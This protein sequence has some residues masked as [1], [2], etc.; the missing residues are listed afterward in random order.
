MRFKVAFVILISLILK[1]TILYSAT[2]LSVSELQT[3]LDSLKTELMVPDLSEE[4]E[5]TLLEQT[6]EAYYYLG[7]YPLSLINLKHAFEKYESIGDMA[8]VGE[9]LERQGVLYTELNDYKTAIDN[10]LKALTILEDIEDDRLISRVKLN[11]ATVYSQLND[12]KQT[13]I[14]VNDAKLFYEKNRKEY[15][16]GYISSLIFLSGI[17]LDQSKPDSALNFLNEALDFLK[18]HGGNFNLQGIYTNIGNVYNEQKEYDQALDFYYKA[19][20]IY[21]ENEHAKG[22]GSILTNIAAILSDQGKYSE[23]LA[24]F[25]EA[26]GYLKEINA[27][28]ELNTLYM[29][30]SITY[31]ELKEFEKSLEYY[32]LSQ[33]LKDSIMS[34]EIQTKIAN[35]Q[36]QYEIK[37]YEQELVTQKQES[38]LRQYILLFAISGL[39]VL[40]IILFFRYRLVRKNKVLQEADYNQEKINLT[41][42]L[43]FKNKQMESFAIHIIQKN[44]FLEKLVSD[45]DRIDKKSL[46]IDNVNTLKN[47]I[48]QN[49]HIEK[50]KEEF[51]NYV[52]QIHQSFFFKLEQKFPQLTK[53]ERRLCSL[54]ILD[55][56][57]KEIADLISISPETVKKVRYRLRKKFELNREDNLV[58][59]LKHI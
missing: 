57:I 53:A 43:E 55:L 41:N 24:N 40:W 12:Y 6:G 58:Q 51:H 42:E 36:N 32:H 59:F 47:S 2:K 1:S 52:D 27:L 17:Y 5:A 45:I 23:A 28:R 14:Y 39:F 44:E 18:N 7:N 49:L 33:E 10:Y 25:E 9:M 4:K 35:L 13:L 34:P 20:Q 8:K 3:K 22:I 50:D 38:R 29:N 37:K 48:K 15:K 56:S 54:L 19:L 21:R 11:I 46:T 16:K 30:M 31:N 26:L